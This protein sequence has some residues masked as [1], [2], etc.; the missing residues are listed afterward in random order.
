[1]R[2]FKDEARLMSTRTSPA[3]APHAEFFPPPRSTR[4]PGRWRAVL[5]A[6]LRELKRFWPVVQN[7]VVQDLRVRYQRSVLGFFWTL[8]NP[9]L[10]MVTLTVV[11]SQ[12]LNEDWRVFVVYL[13]AGMVPWGLLAATL[14][15]C[16]FCIIMNEG[17]IRK[18]FLPK[19]IFPLTR[20]LVNL[21]TFVLSLGAMFL[22]LIPLGARLTPAMALLPV[23]ILLFAMFALALGLIVATANTFYRDCS[24]LVSVLLQAWYFA[25]PILYKIDRLK[26]AS[27]WKFWLNPAYPF[28]R[29]FQVIIQEGRWPSASLILLATAIAFATLGVG[30]ATFKSCEDKLVFRL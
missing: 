9:I 12:L 29:M 17:L 27:Q 25:T 30:Y 10:M 28:I 14:N 13:F 2:T 24:H 8:L 5:R 22:L 19:L 6:D 4:R 26:P 21:T 16:A 3:P 1:M 23:A 18:I 20:L 11:F 7:M 15:D